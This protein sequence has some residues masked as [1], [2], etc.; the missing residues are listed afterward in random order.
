M[1]RALFL[2]RDG[3]IN[4]DH[5]YVSRIEDFQF[6]EGILSLMLD[7]QERG[8]LPVIVTNQSGIGRGYYTREDF[9]CLTEW[10]LEEMRRIGIRIDRSQVFFCPHAPEE[11][12]GCRKPEPGMIL[13]AAERFDLDLPHSWMIGDKV[14]DIQAAFRAGVGHTLLTRKNRKIERKDLHGF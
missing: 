3:V 12:C 7:A 14:S 5:G 13:E 11:R 1:R 6:V 10:M 9:E 4:L 2:D 8:Y